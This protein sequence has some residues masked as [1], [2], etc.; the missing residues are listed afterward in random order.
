ME[1][2]E[3]LLL[4]LV[5]VWLAAKMAGEGIERLGQTAVLGERLAGGISA[6]AFWA[7]STSLRLFTP[8]QNSACLSFYSR[9]A[10]LERVVRVSLRSRRLVFH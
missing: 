7:S 10:A 2:R 9:S 3:L 5:L 8:S 4:G 1:F 6:R